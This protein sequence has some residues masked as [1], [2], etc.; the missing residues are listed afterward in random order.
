M[1]KKKLFLAATLLLSSALAADV[2]EFYNGA[3]LNGKVVHQNDERLTISVNGK[4]TTY[5]KAD[6]KTINQEQR[7]VSPP[8]LPTQT[9]AES[10]RKASTYDLLIPDRGGFTVS[11]SELGALNIGLWTY[12][13]YSNQT[14][15]DDTYIDE[16]GEEQEIT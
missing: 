1:H 2:V 7:E 9:P 16:S 8:P 15:I 14:S 11:D 6:I 10:S 3:V 13:R 12:A 5:S 4:V